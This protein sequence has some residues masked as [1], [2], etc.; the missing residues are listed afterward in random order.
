MDIDKALRDLAE[1][2]HS[3]VARYQARDLG[4]D[5]WALAHRVE[6]GDWEVRGRVL[7]LRGSVATEEQAIMQAVLDAGHGAVA[8]HGSAARLWRLPGWREGPIEVTRPRPR[9]LR[10]VGHIEHRPV[11]LL[12]HHVTELAGIPCTS[13][14]R[15]VFDL[16]GDVR[17]ARVER[18]VDTVVT[19]S[20]A[21]VATLHR[22]LGEL[23]RRGRPGIAVMRALL[24]DRPVGTRVAASGL[25]ARFERLLREAGEP[26]LLRQVDLGGHSW[27]GRVDYVDPIT[28]IVVEIDS[29]L[30]HTSESDKRRDAVR[31]AALKEAGCPKVL[32]IG[33]EH[34]WNEPW[35]VVPAVRQARLAIRANAA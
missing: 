5:R 10:T 31:D 19:R 21:T 16:A 28:R 11:L 20:P 12:P 18:L 13:L 9:G 24:A 26:P 1:L 25:E 22:L 14:A 3:L 29:I 6:R 17:A 27:I 15:T 4:V 30:H 32:R 2:Q 7:R 35:R 34:V 8:S 23:G 33:A